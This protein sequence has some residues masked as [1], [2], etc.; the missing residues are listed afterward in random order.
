MKAVQ[1]WEEFGV[2][3]KSIKVLWTLKY[4]L[5]TLGEANQF[6]EKF[7]FQMNIPKCHNYRKRLYS[8]SMLIVFIIEACKQVVIGETPIRH[9]FEC[10]CASDHKFLL[11][12]DNCIYYTAKTKN[13]TPST[14]QN[15]IVIK[16]SYLIDQTTQS[17]MYL[18]FFA[19]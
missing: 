10:V 13:L 14:T 16:K 6:A 8:K 11:G 18:E 1:K 17:C 3:I 12:E 15:D 19:K 9:S 2:M 4:Y 7:Q 5:Q